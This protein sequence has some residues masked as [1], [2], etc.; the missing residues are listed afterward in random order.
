MVNVFTL[1]PVLAATAVVRLE[2]TPSAEEDSYG[3]VSVPSVYPL[4][5]TAPKADIDQLRDDR[6]QPVDR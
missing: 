4:T 6:A 2:S 3:H 5:L 1:W